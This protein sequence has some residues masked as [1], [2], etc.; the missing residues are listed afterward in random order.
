MRRV[1]SVACC[2][3]L[4]VSSA[5]TTTV[6]GVAAVPAAAEPA[7]V[8]TAAPVP[9]LAKVAAVAT[10]TTAESAA[11]LAFRIDEGLNINSFL[12]EGD[13]AAHL[14]L[15]SGRAPRIIVAFPA[16]NS[17]VG[18]WFAETGAPVTW[19]LASPPRVMRV[20]D[21]KGR[22]LRGIEAEVVANVATLEVKRALLSSVRVLRDYQA[23]STVDDSVLTMPSLSG[24]RLTW[25]RDR[26]DGAA[27]YQLSV[28]TLGGASI[29]ATGRISRGGGDEGLRLKIIALTGETPLTPLGGESLLTNQAAAD[30]RARNALAFLSYEEKYLAGS[31][32]FDTYFGRDTLISLALLAPV[33]QPK[34]IESGIASVL[35]RL[36][37][38][39]E[40]AHEED[41]GE[42]AVLRNEKA[43]RRVAT[44]LYDYAMIDDDFMLAPVVA[45][46]LLG[47]SLLPP[48]AERGARQPAAL[49]AFLASTTPTGEREG[50]ALVRNL[51]WVV[52]RTARFAE[53][54][55]PANLVGLQPGRAAGDWRDSADGLGGGRYPYDVNA[56]LVPAA[57]AA[58][59]RLVHS[60]LL[61][62]Y[63]SNAQRRELRRASAHQRVWIGKAPPLFRV[64]VPANE[65][66]A[67]IAEYASA[68]GIDP[69]P[70]LAGIGGD[71]PLTFNAIALDA[72]GRPVPIV[73]SD[74]TFAL[75]FETPRPP[76]LERAIAVIVRPFPAGLLT[77][78]GMLA[79]NPV[80]AG[81]EMQDK[82]TNAAYHG[83]V[84]W[85]WQQAMMIA[86]LDR[87]LTRTDLQP[88]LRARLA[89]A[90]AQ[91]GAAVD[92]VHDVRTS[93]LWSWSFA[94]GAWRAEPFGQR[95]ADV[96]ESNA[97]QLWST[98]FLAIPHSGVF[99]HGAQQELDVQVGGVDQFAKRGRVDGLSGFQLHV[100][101]AFATPFQQARR[102]D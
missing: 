53:D 68:I 81:R 28:E 10:A 102:V 66:S 62:S 84:V 57:L 47:A 25:A 42:F 22:P 61:D 17:G 39:G 89:A 58:I 71:R 27:G 88:A 64:T 74:D 80:F 76:D 21:G 51:V 26:L 93:E 100:P 96:D 36:A 46:F 63:L 19:Q 98:V 35:A 97:I 13:V 4:T 6:V 14:V 77:P 92:S 31:W 83:T 15:R 59:D 99:L 73:H 72:A 86:G 20:A 82:F 91:V 23:Q 101:H 55:R 8:A 70:S 43:G 75:L 37:T 44:P 24:S 56:I 38:D 49:A 78:I 87:Q 85:S 60:G 52:Q 94:N 33:L 7:L 5:A 67:R 95:L 90:R 65:A 54:P 50:D 11:A 45:D 3:V 9:A 1:A 79:A 48:S 16:G 41:I 34:A 40:V 18:L 32:R 30:P 2:F 12:R 29:D 69:K